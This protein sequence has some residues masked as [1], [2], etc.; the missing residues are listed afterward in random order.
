M[1]GGGNPNH[2][3]KN[4]EFRSGPGGVSAAVKAHIQDAIKSVSSHGSAAHIQQLNELQQKLSD[5]SSSAS[6]KLSQFKT[7]PM[8]LT[9]DHVK[10]T[11]EFRNLKQ[12]SDAA[13]QKL[14]NFNG[15]LS[16]ATKKAMSDLRRSRK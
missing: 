4:G 16:N 1:S 13:F 10:A 9:P 6:K 15:G 12:A 7:G 3:P 11:D 2:D 14:R 8:G 5:E